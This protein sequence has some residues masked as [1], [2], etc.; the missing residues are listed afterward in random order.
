MSVQRKIYQHLA[1]SIAAHIYCTK[2]ILNLSDLRFNY[3]SREN[4]R[5]RVEQLSRD[6]LP[7]GS[8]FDSGSHVDW[9]K[10]TA[11]KLVFY[12]SFH[13]MNSNG[14]YD[15]WTEHNVTVRPA[16][17]GLNIAVSGRDRNDI[18]EYIAVSFEES[19]TRTLVVDPVA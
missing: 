8:G 18:K 11:D 7:S 13:H 12:T 10:S 5:E 9:N 1:N 6:Y 4:H 16:F 15:G 3:A 14:F 19:L 17:E 2:Y